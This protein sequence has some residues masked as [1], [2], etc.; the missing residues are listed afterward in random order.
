MAAEGWEMRVG[1]VV[2]AAK[3]ARG[4]LVR[5]VPRV[6]AAGA[7]PEVVAAVGRGGRGRLV[8]CGRRSREVRVGEGAVGVGEVVP[9]RGAVEGRGRGGGKC[10]WSVFA[11][12]LM[13]PREGPECGE[14]A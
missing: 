10:D 5:G 13:L 7:E 3:P 4:G 14:F 2:G 11:E 1:A 12:E 8:A 6:A 9:S